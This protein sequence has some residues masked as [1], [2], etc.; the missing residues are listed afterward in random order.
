MGVGKGVGS[1]YVSHKSVLLKLHGM[2]SL[3]TSVKMQGPMQLVWGRARE[4]AF[5]KLPGTA[6]LRTTL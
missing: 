4:S 6:G 3:G 1:L 5:L 2:G